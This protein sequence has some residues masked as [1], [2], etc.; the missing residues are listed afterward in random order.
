MTRPRTIFSIQMGRPLS[1]ELR[2]PA[3][4]RGRWERR[5]SGFIQKVRTKTRAGPK[6]YQVGM[7]FQ[8]TI[9]T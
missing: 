2:F 7:Y 3:A 5:R 4:R 9:T 1:R 6:I 8:S